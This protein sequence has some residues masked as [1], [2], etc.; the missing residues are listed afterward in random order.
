[1]KVKRKIEE[2][3]ANIMLARLTLSFFTTNIEYISIKNCRNSIQCNTRLEKSQSVLINM[4][5]VDLM[6]R[7]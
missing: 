5:V 2:N 3:I 7:L 4:K 1:M 6:R